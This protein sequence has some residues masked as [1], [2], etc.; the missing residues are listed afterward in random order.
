MNKS[1]S[2]YEFEFG[3]PSQ[4]GA[5]GIII[6][7]I[8]GVTG[9]ATFSPRLD[10]QG[11]SV[12]GI[13]FFRRI[14]ARL[15]YH[16]FGRLDGVVDPVMLEKFGAGASDVS[17]HEIRNGDWSTGECVMDTEADETR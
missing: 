12:R 6:V 15:P 1:S 17:L 11:N 7:V 3:F 14:A 8:P 10:S 2:F 16:L 9:I 5:S 13:E 4:S